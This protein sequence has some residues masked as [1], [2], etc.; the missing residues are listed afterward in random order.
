MEQKKIF[1]NKSQI[2]LTSLIFLDTTLI[3]SDCGIYFFN[4]FQLIVLQL[5]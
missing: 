2:C 4:F 3:A 1:R 5:L